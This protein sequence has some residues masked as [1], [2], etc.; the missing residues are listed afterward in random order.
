[1]PRAWRNFKRET[2]PGGL[3][4]WVRVDGQVRVQSIVAVVKPAS[5]GEHRF[6]FRA[7]DFPEGAIFGVVEVVKWIDRL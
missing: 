1:M 5:F 2:E 6:V 4:V 3:P 7:A